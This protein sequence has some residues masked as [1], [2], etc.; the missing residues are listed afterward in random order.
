VG[1]RVTFIP[2]D[3]TGP[4]IADATKR[5]LDATGVDFEWD[6]QEAGVDIMEEAGTPLPDS[7]IQSIQDTKV[8][9]KGPIT[10]PVG[11][12]FRS[13]NV[14]LR[15]ALDLYACVRPC[16]SYVGVRSKY[17]DIDIVI[18]RENTEDLYAGI[19]FD[20]FSPEAARVLGFLKEEMGVDLCPSAAIGI[21]PMCPEKTKRLVIRAVEYAL[22]HGLRSVTLM[23][24][25]N[26]MKFTEGGFRK[27]GYE[28]ATA[29]F[30]DRVVTEK[31]LKEKHGGLLPEGR[32]LIRDR[33]ADMVFAEVLQRPQDFDVIAAPNLNGD[34][35]SDALAAQVGGLGIAPGANVGDACA[36]FE[37]THGTA[38][39]LAGK[40]AANPCSLILSGAMMLDHL[41]W[42]EAG[43]L[44]RTGL[45]KALGSGRVTADLARDL[46]GAREVSCSGFGEIIVETIGLAVN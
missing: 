31:E 20:S 28:A 36:V 10:T 25:G 34:Y 23:H 24:K 15:K 27:W 35:I 2:G 1:H 33:I 18:V 45:E 17:E 12:G 22:C 32:V 40:D 19:E 37:A 46:P 6:V 42:V 39:D 4:E 13:V 38:P 29:H 43:D 7:V 30:G 21:K 9:I 26:I 16:K 8:A 11:H 14:A 5:V 41:G 3:G 44:V